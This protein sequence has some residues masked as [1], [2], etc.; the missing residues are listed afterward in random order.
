MMREILK[1]MNLRGKVKTNVTRQQERTK[2][3]LLPCEDESV[4]FNDT[5]NVYIE[6]DNL[7]VLKILQQGYYNKIKMIYI[8]PPYNTGNDFV[9]KDNYK[10]SLENHKKQ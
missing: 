9:Y 1:S 8:D 3:T 4:N 2:V 5:N 10:D 7:E 6:G